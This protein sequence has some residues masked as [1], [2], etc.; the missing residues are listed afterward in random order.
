MI[1]DT[2]ALFALYVPE[3]MSNFV[4]KEIENAEEC[5]FL[6]LIFFEFPNAIR[7][8]VVRK[9]LSMEKGEEIL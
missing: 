7:K 8:R 1:I 4:R 3:K 9:E 6:D 5:Y 2:S